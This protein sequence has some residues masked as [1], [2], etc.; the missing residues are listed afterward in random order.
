[1]LWTW[2]ARTNTNYGGVMDKRKESMKWYKELDFIE[3][4]ERDKT[5]SNY[6]SFVKSRSRTQA[7][8]PAGIELVYVMLEKGYIK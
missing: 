2:S 6:Q 1:M 4:G 8:K 5:I 3:Q 7:S